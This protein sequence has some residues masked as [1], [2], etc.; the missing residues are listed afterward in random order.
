MK[1]VVRENDCS[2]ARDKFILHSEWKSCCEVKNWSQYE[3]NLRSLD[4][5]MGTIILNNFR[6]DIGVKRGQENMVSS[7]NHKRD[8]KS[9]ENS[10]NLL[11]T[12]FWWLIQ[13]KLSHSLRDGV[14]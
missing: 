4:G 5:L 1:N 10:C 2:H 7:V 14:I 12:L 6:Q 3:T 11:Q 9:V 13:P 8:S